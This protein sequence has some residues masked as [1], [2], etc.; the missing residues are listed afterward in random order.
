[1]TATEFLWCS[2][3]TE[4]KER[5]NKKNQKKNPIALLKNCDTRNIKWRGVWTTFTVSFLCETVLQLQG[6]YKDL[7]N[8]P[9]Q[10]GVDTCLLLWQRAPPLLSPRNV[11]MT[12]GPAS[13]LNFPPSAFAVLF[14]LLFLTTISSLLL[15]DLLQASQQR[16]DLHLDLSQL[17][18]DGLQLVCLHCWGTETQK[19]GT[20]IA[21]L[22][23]VCPHFIRARISTMP[24]RAASSSGTARRHRLIL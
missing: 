2:T 19:Q 17:P 4:L 21:T 15:L 24:L 14:P 11:T 3:V 22:T 5:L 9:S 16:V 1:M 12:Y 7:S 6:I 23:P 18:F 20:F 8:K 10:R 13:A